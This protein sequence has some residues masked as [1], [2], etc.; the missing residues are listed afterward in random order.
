MC[1]FASL[2]EC[3]EGSQTIENYVGYYVIG[4]TEK[5]NECTSLLENL[6]QRIQLENL[7]VGGNDNI[8]TNLQETALNVMDWFLLSQVSGGEM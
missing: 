7:G 5:I 8:K 1:L 2:V 6:I 3:K 4:M